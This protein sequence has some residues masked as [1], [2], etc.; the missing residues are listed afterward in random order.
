MPRAGGDADVRWF[1]VDPCYVFHPMNAFDDGDTVVVDVPRHPTMFKQQPRR[2][3]RRRRADA[4][5]VDDR[6]RRGQGAR[7]ADRRAGPGVPARE[8]DAARV[9]PPLR[10]RGERAEHG[11]G[12]RRRALPEAR[13]RRRRVARSTTSAPGRTP[14]EFVFVPERRGDER[15]RRLADGLRVRRGRRPLRPR[16]PRRPRL[17]RARRSPPCTC[18]C[19]CPTA[20]TA[21]GSPTPSSRPRPNRPARDFPSN[22]NSRRVRREFTSES[23][24]AAGEPLGFG[25]AHRRR[26]R[27]AD[28][29]PQLLGDAAEVRGRVQPAE[30]RGEAEVDALRDHERG[31]HVRRRGRRARTGRWRRSTCARSPTSTRGRP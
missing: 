26:R 22:A 12:L 11:D 1:D 19:A 4:R 13:S 6:P 9:A 31:R 10:L 30:H 28:E 5:A 18:P 2:P 25:F 21:A 29:R 8:R 14:G 16:D 17:R 27:A 3:E 20:S 7:G 24:S 23:A 15:G